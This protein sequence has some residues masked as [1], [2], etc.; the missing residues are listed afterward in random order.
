QVAAAR[1]LAVA[2]GVAA[3]FEEGLAERTGQPAAAFD[4]VVA[5]QCWHWF[6]RPLAAAEARRVLKPGGALLICHHDW[7]PHPGTVAHATEFL[8]EAH[9]PRWRLGRGSGMYPA[10]ADD[11]RLA[12]FAD[13]AFAGFDHEA[14][15]AHAAWRGRVRASA[16][17]GGALGPG[18]V[19]R[20]DAE[21]AALL[22][23]RFP[24]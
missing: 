8:I 1:R 5:A 4:L 2:E 7:M 19:A 6:D 10:W 20:F 11:L 22:A 17:I 24:D 9:N 3:R 15:Y 12:G 16:G 18:A 23:A 21:L 14:V 13:L